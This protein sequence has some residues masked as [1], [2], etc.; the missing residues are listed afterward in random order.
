MR[1]ESLLSV[2]DNCDFSDDW[3]QQSTQNELNSRRVFRNAKSP[4]KKQRA[5][6][7]RMRFEARQRDSDRNVPLFRLVDLAFQIINCA[8]QVVAVQFP[9][10]RL[11]V[12]Q[13]AKFI[14]HAITLRL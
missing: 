14:F 7:R 10:Q 6:R 1:V 11:F 2:G 4:P 9:L 3:F 12:L 13:V 5:S 8:L